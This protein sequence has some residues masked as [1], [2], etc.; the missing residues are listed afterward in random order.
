MKGNLSDGRDAQGALQPLQ[1]HERIAA[2]DWYDGGISGAF[3]WMPG[4]LRRALLGG[5]WPVGDACLSIWLRKGWPNG[6]LFFFWKIFQQSIDNYSH[7]RYIIFRLSL[8][9]LFKA[10]RRRTDVKALLKY[11]T[12]QERQFVL[13]MRIVFLVR[14]VLWYNRTQESLLTNKRK[15]ASGLCVY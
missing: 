15:K 9:H 4:V 5:T 3:G 6:S 11:N 1:Q 12:Q 7:L 13:L 10:W 8:R 2:G 14:W